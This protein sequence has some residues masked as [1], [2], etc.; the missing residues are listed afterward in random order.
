[1]VRL[2]QKLGFKACYQT[3]NSPCGLH[4]LTIIVFVT[5]FH[6]DKILGAFHCPICCRLS[7]KSAPDVTAVD[8]V[9]MQLS[10][11]RRPPYC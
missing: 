7:R 11:I 8:H 10:R 9:S 5:E 6:R 1:M 4:A 2:V 3:Q